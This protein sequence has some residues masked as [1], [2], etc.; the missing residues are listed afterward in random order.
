MVAVI[1]KEDAKHLQLDYF[2]MNI[3]VMK[4]HAIVYVGKDL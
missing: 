3:V 2:S 4:D 1:T